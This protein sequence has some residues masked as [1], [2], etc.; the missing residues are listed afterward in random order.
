MIKVTITIT[1]FLASLVTFSQTASKTLQADFRG[2][3]C[4]GGLGFC[5]SVPDTLNKNTSMKN[6]N[7]IK[8]S[9]KSMILELETS[10]LSIEDQ[11]LFFGKEYSKIAPNETLV[12]IQDQDYIFDIDTMIYLELDMGYRMI[13]R[14]SYPLEIIKDKVQ[15]SITLSAYR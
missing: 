9:S 4:Q 12:F 3:L 7:V 5:G 15:V 2:K 13:K 6:F 14:G 10:K 8:T 1:M 11:K